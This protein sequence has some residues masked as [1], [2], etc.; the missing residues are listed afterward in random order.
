[1]SKDKKIPTYNLW[2]GKK[3]DT[4]P[5]E[6]L[7][8]IIEYLSEKYFETTTSEAIHERAVGKAKILVDGIK[9]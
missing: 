5:R 1:V 7:L 3:I 9:N 6:E 4:L 8:K 2:K